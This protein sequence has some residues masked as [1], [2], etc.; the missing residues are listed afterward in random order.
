MC[1][2]Y[3]VWKVPAEHESR[4]Y[5]GMEVLDICK[6]APQ[7]SIVVAGIQPRDW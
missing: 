6:R 2:M 1:Q 5:G 7:R 3:P 4:M